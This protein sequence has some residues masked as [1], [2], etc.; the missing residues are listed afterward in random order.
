M[1]PYL[2]INAVI[3]FIS[4]IVMIILLKNKNMPQLFGTLVV[5][6]IAFLLTLSAS[7]NSINQKTIKPLALQIKA[8]LNPNDEIVAYYKYFQD[9]P[10]Y[11]ERRITI[12]ADWEAKD[13]PFYD[14][15]VRELW[16]GM[17]YQ[18]TKNWL[19]NENIFWQ[20]WNSNKH[21]YVFT[22]INYYDDLKNKS[23]NKIYKIAEYNRTVLLSNHEL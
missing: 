4:G 19:I 17:P 5:T 22:D 11:L 23:K 3:F 14:N 10:I 1:I 8:Q 9:L 13:I 12:V 2:T 16:Y 6:A 7:C 15:W 21:L 18:D 20:R